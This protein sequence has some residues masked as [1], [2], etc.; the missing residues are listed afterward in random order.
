M[1]KPLCMQKNV[2]DGDRRKKKVLAIIGVRKYI[3]CFKRGVAD[4]IK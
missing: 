1:I 4:L 2:P 3:F